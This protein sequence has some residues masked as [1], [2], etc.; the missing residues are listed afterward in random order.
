MESNRTLAMNVANP[1]FMLDKLGQECAPLQFVRELTQNAIDAIA[2]IDGNQ[3]IIWDVDW[4][5]YDLHGVFKLSVT[6]TGVGMTGEEMVKYINSLASSGRTQSFH[7]NFGVGAKVAAGSRNPHGLIYLSWKNGVGSMIHFWRD[8]RSGV[9]GLRQFEQ[10][11]G[12]FEYWGYVDDA[13]KPE[14]IKDHGTKVVL[15][16]DTAD[17]DTMAPLEGT[18]YPAFWLAR[19]LNTRYFRVPARIRI[20]ARSGWTLPRGDQHNFLREVTGQ[21]VFLKD[22]SLA[23]GKLPLENATAHWWILKEK[24]EVSRMGLHNANGHVAALYQDELYEPTSP[25]RASITR[26]QSVF[27]IVFGFQRVVIYVEPVAT[28][29]VTSNMSRTQLVVRNERLPWEHWGNEFRERMPQEIRDFMA[30][31]AAGAETSDHS[32]NIW[33]RLKQVRDLFRFPRYRVTPNGAL[34]G[35]PSGLFA[36]QRQK[37]GNDSGAGRDGDTGSGGNFQ[38]TEKESED[39]YSLFLLEKSEKRVRQEEGIVAPRATWITQANGTRELG[40]LEDRAARYLPK[41]HQLLINAD[42]R[43]FS[44]MVNRYTKQYGSIPN[45]ADVIRATVREWFEQQLVETILGLH[46]LRAS[47]SREWTSTDLDQ[48]WSEAALTA[49]VMPRFH[50]DRII[51]RELGSRLGTL[52]GK[53]MEA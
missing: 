30:E 29:A 41:T 37:R 46:A 49:A 15:L 17:Q 6:D 20:Q 2:T 39:I 44:D 1:T 34:H 10:P 28:D 5:R 14:S 53:G 24:D 33:D 48:A 32:A 18:P 26:L 8:P 51:R 4:P 21:E 9:Y 50:I 12:T 19:Y 45:A 38:A 35:D 23:G 22:N 47:G 31:V 25:G 42:F 40:D 13:V 27:G 16:G 36:I 11:N 7:D 3:E 43:G 52:R